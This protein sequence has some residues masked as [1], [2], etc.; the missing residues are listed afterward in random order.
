LNIQLIKPG[1]AIADEYVAKNPIA[2][3]TLYSGLTYSIAAITTN[4][5]VGVGVEE[6]SNKVSN[7]VN[8]VPNPA[9][10]SFSISVIKNSEGTQNFYSIYDSKGILIAN[11]SLG[12]ISSN[13]SH[14]VDVS[15]YPSGL[16]LLVISIDGNLIT[17]KLI[18]E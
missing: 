2:G 12:K 16:Y 5:N 15:N 9:K 13:Y 14:L 17:K 4:T 18:K 10:D 11:H 3:E 8:V 6:I 7:N 1:G